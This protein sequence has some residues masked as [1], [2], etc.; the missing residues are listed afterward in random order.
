MEIGLGNVD[1]EACPVELGG[2]VAD[3]VY[4]ADHSLKGIAS[5]TDGEEF[6]GGV[7]VVGFDSSVG[8]W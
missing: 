5:G 4:V 2:G 1:V 8:R 7:G 6:V 3:G